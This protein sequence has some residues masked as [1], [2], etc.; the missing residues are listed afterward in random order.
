[1]KPEE[2]TVLVVDDDRTNSAML[3]QQIRRE[4]YNVAVAENG[5]QAL[6]LIRA[7]KCDLILLDIVMPEMDGHQ[8]LKYLKAAH[9]LRHIPVIV[10][11]AVD[12]LDSVVRCIELGAEDYI[13]K[14]ANQVILRARIGAILEKKWLRDQEQVY[15]K[16][17][18]AEQERSEHLLLNILPKTIAERLKQGESTIA[19]K[20]EDVTVLFAD[21][22]AFTTLC[23]HKRPAEVVELLNEIFSAF[24]LLTEEHGLEKIKTIGDSYMVA[25]GLTPPCR[26]SAEAIAEMALGI[27]KEIARFNEKSSEPLSIRT[28]ID[29]GPVLAGVIG[30]K[31]FIYDIWGNTV[32][33]AHRMQ[34]HGLPGCVQ[35]T[36]AT[37]D[38]L[39]SKYL[40]EE[41]GAIEVKGKGKVVTY[42]LIGRAGGPPIPLM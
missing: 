25:G 24:D 40:F 11:S 29:T 31:R 30:R 28:G 23:V 16:A 39:R 17:L 37:Y 19:D 27:Q 14:P 21:I 10:I 38:R 15:L 4:G 26:N 5:R 7:R 35:V 2:A 42:F 6:D 8:L 18:E 34:S 41:R 1:M 33:T 32:N 36:E 20:F 12:E 9:A 22:V 3:S 13:H